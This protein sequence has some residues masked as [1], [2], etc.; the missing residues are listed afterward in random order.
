MG[1]K[2]RLHIGSVFSIGSARQQSLDD[3]FLSMIAWPPYRNYGSRPACKEKADPCLTVSALRKATEKI[4]V[5]VQTF[6][7]R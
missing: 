7:R 6:G 2:P 1:R 5:G 3:G 4:E